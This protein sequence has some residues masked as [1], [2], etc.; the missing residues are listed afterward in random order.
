M[1][2]DGKQCYDFAGFRLDT[3][4]KLLLRDGV[5]VPLT[6]KVFDTLQ[7]FVQNPSQ[8]LGKDELIEKIWPDHFVEESNLTSNI[9]VLRKALGDDAAHPR[10]IE[11]VPRRGYRFIASIDQPGTSTDPKGNSP[12]QQRKSWLRGSFVPSG[13][14]IAAIVVVILAVGFGGFWYARSNVNENASPL[15]TNKFSSEKLST[16]GKVLHAAVSTDGKNVVYT[17]GIEG[18]QSVWLRQLETGNNIQ[19]IPPSTD[20]YDWLEIAPDGS[21]LYFAR[22]PHWTEEPRSI[23]RVS[24]FGGVPQKIIDAT[25]GWMSI[26]ADGSKI[27]FV[28]CPELDNENCSL[29]LADTDGKNERKLVTRSRPERIGD[30]EISPDGRSIIFAAGQSQNAANEFGLMEVNIETGAER[31]VTRE[32]FFHIRGIANLR[33][34]DGLLITASRIPN[35]LFSIWRVSTS[36]GLVDALTTDSENYGDLSLD[37]DAKTLVATK[38]KQSYRLFVLNRDAPETLRTLADAST[39]AFAPDGSIIFS[40]PLSGNDEIW[41]IKADGSDQRQLTTSTADEDSPV[42]SPDKSLIFFASNRSGASQVWRMNADGSDQTQITRSAGGTPLFVSPDGA[43]VYYHHALDKNLWRVSVRGG[44]ELLAL[45]TRSHHFSISPDGSHVAC[46]TVNKE[47]KAI[48]VANLTNG[49]ITKAIKIADQRP[50]VNF[51]A[52]MPDSSEIAFVSVEA[53]ENYALRLQSMDGSPSR[54]IANLGNERISSFAISPDGK[55][56]AMTQGGWNHDAVLLK[57][58][59]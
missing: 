55:T 21:T 59:R 2:P 3:I 38:T 4:Q 22:R 54:K 50:V 48:E 24:I 53:D 41:R 47:G 6:P 9:K 19:I 20:F 35:K 44:E 51:L 26:S 46:I 45:N 28:R 29:W 7:I 16:N 37:R 34:G 5:T 40:S 13:L 15:L 31:E 57:G 52:W 18:K 39:V 25:E 11:T 8:L 12:E 27:S 1:S 10:F 30:N 58:L 23:Y 33:N 17:N 49:E 32:K 36:T 14:R 56:F 43:W 42:A